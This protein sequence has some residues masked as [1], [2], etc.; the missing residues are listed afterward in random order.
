MP[1]EGAQ[2]AQEI[3]PECRVSLSLRRGYRVTPA[4]M[5]PQPFLTPCRGAHEL[6]KGKM[7][8]QVPG[9]TQ[10]GRRPGR[11]EH[12]TP[13]RAGGGWQGGAAGPGKVGVNPTAR[14]CPLPS[15]GVAG[16]QPLSWSR[17]RCASSPG[18]HLP[19]Q[20]LSP[21]LCRTRCL[22]PRALRVPSPAL[23]MGGVP[24]LWRVT[25]LAGE[26]DCLSHRLLT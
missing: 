25:K 2:A 8:N 26:P 24:T 7:P 18:V 16:G 13:R 20:S 10:G 15:P 14:S 23:Q 11:E 9:D 4:G 17:S 19:L 5:G 6:G 12:Q 21:H 22:A 3:G 1:W